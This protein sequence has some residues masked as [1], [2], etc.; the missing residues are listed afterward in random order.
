MRLGRQ[1]SKISH[2]L[3]ADDLQLFAEASIDQICK[4]QQSFALFCEALGLKINFSKTSIVFSKNVQLEL[5]VEILNRCD[6]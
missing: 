4:V 6:F 5:K 2:L 3:F 1:D